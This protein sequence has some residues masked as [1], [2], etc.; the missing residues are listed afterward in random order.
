MVIKAHSPFQNDSKMCGVYV[1]YFQTSA[2]SASQIKM[3]VSDIILGHPN[4]WWLTNAPPHGDLLWY[5]SFHTTV[6]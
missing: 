2:N 4:K 3:S 1:Q 6:L 5:H